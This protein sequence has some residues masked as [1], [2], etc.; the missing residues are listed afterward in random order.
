MPSPPRAAGSR[1]PPANAISP[2]VTGFVGMNPQADPGADRRVDVAAVLFVARCKPGECRIRVDEIDACDA[3]GKERRN[4]VV[5]GAG[6]DL[7]S[8]GRRT[9]DPPPGSRIEG[10]AGREPS[11][12]TGAAAPRR[13][14]HQ[15]RCARAGPSVATH[16]CPDTK[17]CSGGNLTSPGS[18]S[19]RTVPGK[20]RTRAA[21]DRPPDRRRRRCHREQEACGAPGRRPCGGAKGRRRHD[22]RG[23]DARAAAALRAREPA[24]RTCQG[25]THPDS[26]TFN[27][28]DELVIQRRVAG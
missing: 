12:P 7:R 19:T 26:A 16:H 15:R 6:R 1:A 14:G 25:R 18:T 10:V 13:H 20:N 9:C 11:Q 3:R 24:G 28:A 22:A 23:F 21:S 5:G 17:R 4:G 8:H 2:R 27:R